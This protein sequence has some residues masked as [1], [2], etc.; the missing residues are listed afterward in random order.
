LGLDAAGGLL[1]VGFCQYSTTGEVDRL[2]EA[3][4]AL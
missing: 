4:E 3:L 2:L 1:R